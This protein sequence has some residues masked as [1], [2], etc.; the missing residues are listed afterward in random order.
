MWFSKQISPPS[1]PKD[2]S[3][4]RRSLASPRPQKIRSWWVGIS[5][6]WR[7]MTSPSGPMNSIVL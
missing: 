1:L 7:P 6:R 2:V 3:N 5:F 4:T